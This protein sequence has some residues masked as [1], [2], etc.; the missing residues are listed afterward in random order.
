MIPLTQ[1][2][3]PPIKASYHRRRISGFQS[4]MPTR[5]M[6][7]D[8]AECDDRTAQLGGRHRRLSPPQM[9]TVDQSDSGDGW[10]ERWS[11]LPT[12]TIDRAATD[13]SQLVHRRHQPVLG[14]SPGAT[15]ID[16]EMQKEGAAT[17]TT[18]GRQPTADHGRSGTRPTP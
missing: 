10:E 15:E 4:L 5:L 1:S 18:T 17:R 6:F 9:L 7:D 3:K 16:M 14:S 13:Y 8:T 11:P 2:D 12:T